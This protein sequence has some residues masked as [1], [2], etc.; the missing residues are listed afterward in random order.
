LASDGTKFSSR[1]VHASKERGGPLSG[2]GEGISTFLTLLAISA[3]LGSLS[4]PGALEAFTAR[5]GRGTARV[6]SGKTKETGGTLG[7]GRGSGATRAVGA[8]EAR[9]ANIRAC[10]GNRSRRANFAS[11]IQAAAL[12][13]SEAGNSLV[14]RGTRGAIVLA[15]KA[16]EAA[17][18]RVASSR[19]RGAGRGTDAILALRSGS[20]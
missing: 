5:V 14:A 9:S 19:L 16:V 20:T 11:A 13:S 2:K 18:T 10:G 12:S 8:P 6:G 15:I 1:A 7:A 3:R 4:T 17:R